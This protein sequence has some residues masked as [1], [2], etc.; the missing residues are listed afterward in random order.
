VSGSLANDFVLEFETHDSPLELDSGEAV[1]DLW[2]RD[3]GPT[4]ML[5]E[6]LDGGRRD[7]FHERSRRNGGIDFSR[8]YLL[9][10]GTRRP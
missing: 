10:L 4:R 8:T 7:E 9:T 1:W 5:A 2:S 6:T 3:F